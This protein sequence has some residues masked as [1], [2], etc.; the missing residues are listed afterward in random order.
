[1]QDDKPVVALAAIDAELARR[2]EE[3]MATLAGQVPNDR[4]EDLVKARGWVLALCWSHLNLTQ[5]V[6]D[7]RKDC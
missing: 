4:K 3:L 6:A 7:R 2:A 5:F 1:M